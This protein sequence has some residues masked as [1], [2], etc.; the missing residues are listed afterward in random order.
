[1]MVFL[2][3]VGRMPGSG[4]QPPVIPD[5][6]GPLGLAACAT[7]RALGPPLTGVAQGSSVSPAGGFLM[8]R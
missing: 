7:W 3:P 4:R 2:L 8:P 5:G 1:M 6:V